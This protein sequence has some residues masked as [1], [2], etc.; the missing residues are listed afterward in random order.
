MTG[1]GSSNPARSSNESMR[2]GDQAAVD[3]GAVTQFGPRDQGFVEPTEGSQSF[4]NP[5]CR[6]MP[7]A[8][9]NAFYNRWQEAPNSHV[10]RHEGWNDKPKPLT[11][12]LEVEPRFFLVRATP[13]IPT[14]TACQSRRTS[15]GDH[16]HMAVPKNRPAFALSREPYDD[17]HLVR[18][19]LLR[20][21]MDIAIG[22]PSSL[23]VTHQYVSHSP[24]TYIVYGA[25]FND[26]LENVMGELLVIWRWHGPRGR[27]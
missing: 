25:D 7:M 8:S 14:T 18:I 3:V 2:T 9:F 24:G 12:R 16:I 5:S 20:Q 19:L 26:L 10:W 15:M 11:P 4:P 23:E 22:E 21:H 1:L 13:P 17:I 27:R 6:R